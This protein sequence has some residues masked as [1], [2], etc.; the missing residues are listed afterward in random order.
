MH[1]KI[2][3]PSLPETWQK[4]LLQQS[5]LIN[6]VAASTL[7][8]RVAAD[9]IYLIDDITISDRREGCQHIIEAN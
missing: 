1:H 5:A 7:I 2:K 8:N 3:V 4:Y 6:W 9:F